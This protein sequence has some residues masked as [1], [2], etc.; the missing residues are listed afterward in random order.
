MGTPAPVL[1]AFSLKRKDFPN[2][3]VFGASASAF[4]YEGAV[5]KDGRGPSI[6]DTFLKEN[7]PDIVKDGGLEAIGH[8]YQYKDDVRVMKEMGIDSYRFSISWSRVLPNGRRTD[9]AEVGKIENGV[10][11]EGIKFY[12]DLINELIANDIEPMVTLFHWDVPQALENEYLGFLDRRIVQDFIGFA[13]LCFSRFGDRV[14]HWI[15]FNEP[16]SFSVGGYSMGTFAPGRGASAPNA[17]IEMNFD[18]PPSRATS[19]Q[20]ISFTLTPMSGDPSTE[21]YIV[22][23]NQLLAHA[24]AVELYRLQY[25]RKQMGKIGITLVSFWAVPYHDTKEDKDAAQR[26]IDFMFGWFMDPITNGDYPSSMRSLVGW[27][28]PTFTVMESQLLKG[29]FDFLGFN[30]YTSNY[31][32][33]DPPNPASKPHYKT[34]SQAKCTPLRDGVPIGERAAS[35]WLYVYPK[36]LMEHLDYIRKHYKN[37]LVIITENGCDEFNVKDLSYWVAFFDDKRMSYHYK[38]LQF[39]KKAIDK[40]ANIQGY[41]IWSL[42]DNLE[43]S[44]GFQTRFGMNFIDFKN[45]LKRY[46][47]LSSAWYKFLL[48]KDDEPKA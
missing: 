36:G 24:K 17:R 20:A 31:V 28:L 30:Y 25:Q 38:H 34:D 7:Y 13:D 47:K 29:S 42:M 14:K 23:H 1:P 22:S 9:R 19:K 37:P 35:D 15:T 45:D 46:P 21:P 6:W 4:Q 26:A 10:N 32:L 18:F 2:G 48:Q 43:W 8:Y 33:N 11:E 3:F 41:Y 40:G 27:R 44:S 39:V 5:D 16:W 12:N